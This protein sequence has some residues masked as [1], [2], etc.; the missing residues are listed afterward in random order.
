MLKSEKMDRMTLDDYRGAIDIPS[1]TGRAH[2]SYMHGL[3]SSLRFWIL[4][5]G[6]REAAEFGSTPAGAVPDD[7]LVPE[8]GPW[9]IMAA[10]L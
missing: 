7:W 2:G 6:A 8:S 1:R 4:D 5:L 3:R 10:P 9:G